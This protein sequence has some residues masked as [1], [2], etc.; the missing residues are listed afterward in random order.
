MENSSNESDYSISKRKKK[1]IIQ[2]KKF[3]NDTSNC[4]SANNMDSIELN[5]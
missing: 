4:N 3:S 2:K 1:K 5:L